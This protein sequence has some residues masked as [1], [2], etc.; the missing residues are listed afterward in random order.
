[1]LIVYWDIKQYYYKQSFITLLYYQSP[2][3]IVKHYCISCHPNDLCICNP[4]T[5]WPI[6]YPRILW[7]RSNIIPCSIFYIHLTTLPNK[8]F[9][10][11]HSAVTLKCCKKYPQ[12]VKI[13]ILGTDKGIGNYLQKWVG[14]DVGTV[15]PPHIHIKY[16][17]LFI[18]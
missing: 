16:N 12:R 18:G 17:Y 13:L 8:K 1:M 3:Y 11:E 10:I 5:Q 14:M 6:F 9:T 7:Y 2:A 15:L 4:Y